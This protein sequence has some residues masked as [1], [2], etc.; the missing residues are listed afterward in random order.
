MPRV[1]DKPKS[2][3]RR[4]LKS[5]NELQE[6]EDI[7]KAIRRAFQ[8]AQRTVSIH[9]TQVAILKTIY[10]RCEILE[11]SDQFSKLFC[12]LVN[13]V[14]PVKKGEPA[15]DRIIKFVSSFVTSINPSIKRDGTVEDSVDVDEDED[16]VF[17]DFIESLTTHLMKGLDASN[18]NVRYRVCHLLSHLM[19]NMSAIDKDLYDRLSQEL[20]NRIYDKEPSVRIKAITTLASFQEPDGTDAISD[21]AKKIRIIMQNDSNPEVRRACLKQIEKNEY[22]HSYIFERARDINSVNRRLIYS[23][24]LPRFK[25]FRIISADDR[26]RLLASGLR[27]RDETVRKAAVKWLTD[28]WLP[29]LDNDLLEFVERLKVTDNDLAEAALRAL[30][31]HKNEMTRKLEFNEEVVKNLTSEYALLFR[32]FFQYCND[33]KLDELLDKNFPAAAEFADT[34]KM[35]FDLRRANS[36]K[37][38]EHKEELQG[39]EATAEDLGILDPEEYDYIILQLLIIASEFD[40]HDEFG[41]SKM[42]N[43]LRSIL[44]DEGLNEKIINVLIQCI[45]KLSINE[46]DFSQIIVEIINDVRDSVSEKMAADLPAVDETIDDAGSD[47][48]DDDDEFVDAAT[49]MSRA[50][51]RSANKSRQLE[52]EKETRQVAALPP[53]VLVECLTIT[54]RMLELIKEPLKDNLY[55]E[56]ILHNLIRPS[57]QRTEVQIRIL[58]LTCMGLCCILDKDLAIRNMFLCGVFITKSDDA[59]LII[60]GLKVIADL[61][62]VHGVSILGVDVEGSIDAMAVAKL[63]YR[64]LRD[65]S[66]KEVQAVSGEAL[67]KLFLSGIINDDELFETTLLAYFNPSINDNEALKQCLSF[68]IP[69]YAFSLVSHQEQIS[70]VVADT[71]GRLFDNWGEMEEEAGEQKMITQQ[72]VIQQLL[73]WTDPYRIVNREPEDAESSPIQIDVAIQLL[74]VLTKYDFS[75]ESKPFVKAILTMLPK[76]T[77]TEHSGLERLIELKEA[78]ESDELLQGNL[79]EV[80]LNAHFRNPYEKFKLYVEDCIKKARVIEG[81]AEIVTKNEEEEEAARE[82]E[83]KEEVMEAAE[84]DVENEEEGEERKAKEEINV[85]STEGE[86]SDNGVPLGQSSFIAEIDDSSSGDALL[87]KDEIID[88]QDEVP[89]RARG[90]KRARNSVKTQKSKTSA[91]IKRVKVEF[92]KEDKQKEESKEYYEEEEAEEAEEAEEIEEVEEAEEEEAEE[93]EWEDEDEGEDEDEDLADLVPVEENENENDNEDETYVKREPVVPKRSGRSARKQKKAIGYSSDYEDDG[94]SSIIILSDDD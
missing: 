90:K 32:V 24:V 34:L 71:L 58:A 38:E 57:L 2:Q 12:K 31:D 27:D 41:R 64:T 1:T 56:S 62:A 20:L 65:S 61:L 74:Q 78:L 10:Q 47:D 92:E 54:K 26:N 30:L 66:R 89:K 91:S 83:T 5:L 84:E 17:S 35:Y 11:L 43:V 3:G 67:Y 48:D 80:L 40:Y 37:I 50:S 45:R 85:R 23:Y 13:K 51:V 4:Y 36:L 82:E 52:L 72:G 49:S 7:E 55:L 86:D 46:R 6:K 79:D 63:F 73:Y 39:S 69:V 33:N 9:K 88:E 42:L 60:A 18:K 81:V 68:C 29:T 28:T 70:R 44:S 93:R 77:F 75:A 76:L 14:L 53:D 25:D 21:A 16:A 59:Q 94:E 19:H 22:T 8:E 15:A 87:V